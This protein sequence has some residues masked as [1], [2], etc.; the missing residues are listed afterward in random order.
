MIIFLF[1]GYLV[2]FMHWMNRHF[3]SGLRMACLNATLEQNTFCI[4]EEDEEP[5]FENAF[6]G[7]Y[8]DPFLTG[9]IVVTFIVLM[10]G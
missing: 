8:E 4:F 7:V 9:T 10:I 1:Q 3:F 5:T 6:S 2:D